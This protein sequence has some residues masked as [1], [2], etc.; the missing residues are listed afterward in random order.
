MSAVTPIISIP[1]MLHAVTLT[2]S[3][4]VVLTHGGWCKFL[5]QK[6]VEKNMFDCYCFSDI[7]SGT[8]IFGVRVRAAAIPRFIGQNN[9]CSSPEKYSQEELTAEAKIFGLEINMTMYIYTWRKEIMMVS[10]STEW[11]K[12]GGIMNECC[13]N[14]NA[15]DV[16]AFFAFSKV[17][18]VRV[19][20]L[21]FHLHPY[22]E[23]YCNPLAWTF[24]WHVSFPRKS[25]K[26]NQFWWNFRRT[27]FLTY[28]ISWPRKDESWHQT[29]T[30]IFWLF[31]HDQKSCLFGMALDPIRA[32]FII[33]LQM[34]FG[35]LKLFHFFASAAPQFVNWFGFATNQS[36]PLG[37]FKLDFGH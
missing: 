32:A 18:V 21:R 16:S 19:C 5:M 27:M 3:V 20:L 10:K 14:I 15:S 7:K 23:D 6:Y 24:A 31:P 4:Y 25:K 37:L 11:K 33:C 8:I 9:C 28:F 30:L 22:L 26:K 29:F 35:F 13:L 1:N 12:N 17:F 2:A 34:Q 36:F